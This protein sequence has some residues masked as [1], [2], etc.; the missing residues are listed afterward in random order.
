MKFKKPSHIKIYKML[1]LLKT[2]DTTFIELIK[3]LRINADL[4]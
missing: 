4:Q 1:I 2:R 3:K